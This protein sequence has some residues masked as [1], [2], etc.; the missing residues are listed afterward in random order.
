MFKQLYRLALVMVC[1]AALLALCLYGDEHPLQSASMDAPI[2]APG[3]VVINEVAWGGTGASANDEWLELYNITDAAIP[4]TGWRI[5]AST[6]G[7]DIDLVGSIPP[8]GYFLLER[9]DDATLSD[10]GADQVYGNDGSDWSFNNAGEVLTLT[11]A[12][13]IVIDTANSDGGNWPAGTTAATMERSN[14]LLGDLNTN[15]TTNNG[16]IRNGLD[17]AGNPLN[18]TPRCANSAATP[19]ADLQVTKT[20]TSAAPPGAPLTYTLTLRNAGNLLAAGVT[21]TDRLPLSVTYAGQS[22]PYTPLQPAPHTLV[23]PLGDLAPTGDALRI[24]VHVTVTGGNWSGSITNTITATTAAPDGYAPNNSA[25]FATTIYAPA[26]HLIATRRG[27]TLIYHEQPLTYTLTVTN[28]GGLEARAVAVTET[29]PTGMAFVGY[30]GPYTLTQPAPQTL[31]WELSSLAPG[32]PA[33]LAY[34]ATAS[35]ALPPGPTT[36]TAQVSA[37]GL[38]PLTATW[39]ATVLPYVRVYALHPANFSGSKESV[40]LT[41]LGPQSVPLGGWCIDDTPSSGTRSCLP[42]GASIA[43][44]ETL[45]LAQDANGFY[46]QWGFEAHWGDPAAPRPGVLALTGSWPGFTDAG[47]ALYLLNNSNIAVD[48]LAYGS[49][50]PGPGWNGVAVPFPYA[51]YNSAAQVLYRKLDQNT[52]A[53]VADTDRAAD[54][55]QDPADPLNGRKVRYPGWDLETLFFPLEITHT[56]HITIAVAPEGMLDIVSQTVASAQHTLLIEGYTLESVPLYEV[57]AARIQ[58]GVVITTLLERAPAGGMDPTE[59][60]IAQRLHQP[61]QSQVYFIGGS[62][63]RY[64]YQHAKFILV[65]DRLALISTDNFSESSMPSDLIDNGTFGHRGFIALTDDPQI[66][67]R[68]KQIFTLDCDP[69]HHS[70]IRPYDSAFAPPASYIPIPPV[71]WTF[72]PPLFRAPLAITATRLTLL[73]SPEQAL[74]DQDAL[75]GLLGRVGAGDL[76]QT[77]QLDEPYTWKEDAGEAGLNPRLQA[78]VAAARRGAEVQILLDSFYDDP[79]A[80]GSNNATCL[81]LNALARSESLPLNCRMGNVTGLGIH[82]KL[83]LVQ[84]GSERWVN[85]GSINGSE[86]SNKANREIALQFESPAAYDALEEVF[87]YDWA[88]GSGP[89]IFTQYLPLAFKDYLGP[90]QHVLITEVMINPANPGGG[91]E[92]PW[93]WV[94]LYNPTQ[95]TVALGGWLI[96]D[97]LAA[98]DYGD[99]RYQFP[100]ETR[101]LPQQIII[102]AACAPEFSAAYGFNPAYE[103]QSCDPLVP[104]LA[105]AGSWDGFGIALGNT[106]DELMLVDTNGAHVDSV[107]WGGEVRINLIPFLNFIA[108]F[109]TGATLERSPGNS[110]YNDCMR[111]FRIRYTPRPGTVWS[112]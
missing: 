2:V 13:A 103:W 106:A 36:N 79:I 89:L 52:G 24:T 64:R 53:P 48:A 39:T 109:P 9:T 104:D 67:A 6:N 69:A 35:P 112:P 10:I 110:D 65:D 54:W 50:T 47:E 93:E 25:Q 3:D 82:A 98:G 58:A 73:Q 71:D 27:P 40:A 17:A 81:T 57:L 99:G 76:V 23:W 72:Y 4:L 41:N 43:P 68:L 56:T 31:R 75:L 46:A 42:P 18:G 14:P 60:W 1:G 92:T 59:K 11:N 96:G 97:A 28:T 85:L 80:S 78:L 49:G 87:A 111:D 44:G 77:M 34:T 26:P 5:E 84:T 86:N 61:P 29:L 32:S 8:H 88:R 12:S 19:A 51:G 70:D 101:L 63:S 94:E 33:L 38:P 55:A 16:I 37:E 21:L 91:T 108:P 74:R 20:G 30:V 102:V 15:W 83:F 100:A 95:E 45:W 22:S 105:P 62:T 66:I 107:A 90:A 7:P